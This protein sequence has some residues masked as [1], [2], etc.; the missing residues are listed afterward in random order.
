LHVAFVILERAREIGADV[1]ALARPLD[2]HAKVVGLLANR[3][4]EVA[5]G[6]QPP[7]PLEDLLRGAL[8]LP[9]I[10]FGGLRFEFRQ[11]AAESRFV[12]APSA[13]RRRGWKV[14]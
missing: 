11:L 10:R 6:L 8:V 2:Q 13:D 4:R 14:R 12:K 1:L 9:E 5:L 7:A 3:L